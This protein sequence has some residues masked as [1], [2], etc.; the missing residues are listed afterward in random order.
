MS[1]L[2][3]IPVQVARCRSPKTMLVNILELL[4]YVAMIG[5]TVQLHLDPTVV[6]IH[7]NISVFSMGIIFIGSLRS[8]NTLIEEMH[9]SITD[10]KNA[11]E[12]QI[13]TMTS[14]DAM[15][16]PV[17][18]GGV[19]CGLYGMMKYFGK[20]IVNQCLLVYIAVGS[21]AGVK[22]LL[23][24][25]TF[26]NLKF[27]DGPIIDIKNKYFELRISIL[28]ILCFGISLCLMAGYVHYKSWI[29]NNVICI[30]FCIHALQSLFLGNFQVGMLLLV[31]LFFYD[32]Y[33][34]FG[35]DIMLTVAKN[36]D[37]PIK[38]M[39]PQDLT[40]DPPKHNILG[41]GDIVLPG[42]FVSLCLRFDFL[43]TLDIDKLK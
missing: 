3:Q 36:I 13:E 6:P 23:L 41:L 26:D 32:I 2:D 12:S 37:A 27:L 21:T 7:V 39:F 17:M 5:L 16:F 20:E 1:D 8:L 25:I 38:L 31:L 30:V 42:V 29:F 14:S 40:V 33:F 18:A 24:T 9:K 15:Q 34:V 22:S 19:L 11:G 43:K 4:C 35:T 10:P 28:D